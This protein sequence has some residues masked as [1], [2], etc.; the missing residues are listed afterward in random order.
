MTRFSA[1]SLAVLLGVPLAPAAAQQASAPVQVTTTAVT[2]VTLFRIV[3]GQGGAY[4]RDIVENLIPIYE[5]FKKAG[6]I[7]EYSFFSKTTSESPTDW[8]AGVSLTYANF[9]GL[10]NFGPR[11]NPI[12]LK[13]YGSA[14]KRAAA[15][16]ARGGM[17][18]AI[19]SFL[20]QRLAFNR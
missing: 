2:R 10:D 19:S 4:N 14:E 8:N 18:T 9:A 16:T 6:L 7:T 5:E 12:T 11:A 3:P 13:H 15:L 20:T 17:R 1:V